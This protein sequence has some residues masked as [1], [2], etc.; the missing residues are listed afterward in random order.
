MYDSNTATQND[1]DC[2][3]V[4]LAMQ[5]R[6]CCVFML[7]QTFLLAHKDSASLLTQLS[8]P[9]PLGSE[10]REHPGPRD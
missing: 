6:K 8:N 7:T 5:I 3:S 9:S 4:A 2:N 1:H 10:K